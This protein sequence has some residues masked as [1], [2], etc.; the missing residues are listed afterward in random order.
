MTF[1]KLALSDLPMLSEWLNRRHVA[2]WWGGCQSLEEVREKYSPRLTN[3]STAVPY[4][5][6]LDCTPIGYIQSYI[7]AATGDGWWPDERDPGVRGIDQ[8]LA[9]GQRLDQ[10]LGTRMVK[11]FVQFLFRDPS[12]TRIQADPAP[13]NARAIRC[14]EKAGFRRVSLINTPDGPAM[15]M[16]IDRPS[17]P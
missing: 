15:L 2:E 13:I 10:G 9:D 8:F 1:Q 3:E 4:L 6:Y 5:A 14:Y 12:V 16:V 17:P 7:A 11:E